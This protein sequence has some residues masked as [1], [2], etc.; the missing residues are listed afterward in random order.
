MVASKKLRYSGRS[1]SA[2]VSISSLGGWC[3][4]PV[5]R[6]CSSL[7]TASSGGANGGGLSVEVLFGG[8]GVDEFAMSF[9]SWNSARLCAA[10]DWGAVGRLL[11]VWTI[12]IVARRRVGFIV[13][14]WLA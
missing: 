11:A 12:K 9:C 4:M 13:G 7:A 3:L 5:I 6:S 2:M 1:F 10:Q 14:G 8:G